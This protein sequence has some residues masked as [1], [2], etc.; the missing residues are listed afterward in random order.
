LNNLEK[1]IAVLQVRYPDVNFYIS[2]GQ[3]VWMNVDIEKPTDEQIQTWIAELKEPP[4][5][6]RLLKE[7][8][9]FM[10]KAQSTTNAN[11]F[12]LLLSTLTTI[13][14]V[15]Y[16]EIALTQIRSAMKQPYTAKELSDLNQLF[17][18][19]NIE[20]ILK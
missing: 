17:T 9:P 6:D 1:T 12:A 14:S 11:G 20:L 13:R 4:D 18:D 10:V 2:D 15:Q 3:L 16:L 7:S 19:C 5:W 8:G